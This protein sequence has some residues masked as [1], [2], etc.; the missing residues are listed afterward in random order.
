MRSGQLLEGTKLRRPRRMSTV[1]Y[2]VSLERVRGES[3]VE[4]AKPSSTGAGRFLGE[5]RNWHAKCS[6]ETR[7]S[8]S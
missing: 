7:A 5:R 8:S 4:L 2:Q 1:A 6:E 3:I